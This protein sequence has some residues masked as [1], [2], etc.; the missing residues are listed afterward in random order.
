MRSLHEWV[1]KGRKKF[2]KFHYSRAF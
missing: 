1:K 2:W